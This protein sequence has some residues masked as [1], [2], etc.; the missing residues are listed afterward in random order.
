MK[1]ST[2]GRY[3]IKAMLDLA[4]HSEEGPVALKSIAERQDISDNYLE[5]LFAMLRKAGHIKSIRGSQGGYLLAQNPEDIVIGS[6]LRALEGSLAPVEC[7]YEDDTVKCSQSDNCV[8]KLIWE[9]IR[10][11]VNE[12]VDSITLKDL[13]EDYKKSRNNNNYI[14]YI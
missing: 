11:S 7:V 8:T 14:Y 6:V 9:K 1:L 13:V 4:L 3:G 10:N 12:V 2:K 5:Q